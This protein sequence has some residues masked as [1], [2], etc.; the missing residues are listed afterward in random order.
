MR[1]AG[2]GSFATAGRHLVTVWLHRKSHTHV[3]LRKIL[4]C[5]AVL[6]DGYPRGL[7]WRPERNPP[8]LQSQG[9]CRRPF[10]GGSAWVDQCGSV[11]TQPEDL[12][13]R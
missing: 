3:L 8:V 7:Y 6:L 12:E 4:S 2:W 10:S 11:P 1:V 5:T 13:Q 9:Q